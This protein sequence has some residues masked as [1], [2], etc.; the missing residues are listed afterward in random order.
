MKNNLSIIHG[1]DYFSLCHDATRKIFFFIELVIFFSILV[2]INKK[3]SH[4]HVMESISNA[5]GSGKIF[6]RRTLSNTPA[7]SR[8][9]LK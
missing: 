3:K 2:H 8:D 4:G 1:Y 6:G 5:L 7:A 9:D